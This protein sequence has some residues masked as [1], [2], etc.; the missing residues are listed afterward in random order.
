MRPLFGPHW[1][2]GWLARWLAVAPCR[3]SLSRSLVA[4]RY[5][6]LAF[7]RSGRT[8]VGVSLY[9]LICRCETLTSEKFSANPTAL[10]QPRSTQPWAL[11]DLSHQP[12][13]QQ[14]QAR[15]MRSTNLP[16]HLFDG[17]DPMCLPQPA[18]VHSSSPLRS[19]SV[20]RCFAFGIGVKVR[21]LEGGSWCCGDL[22]Q[23]DQSPSGF[24]G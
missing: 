16:Q 19:T 6:C 7:A 9:Q 21:G 22:P 18:T 1:L 15:P 14:S 20:P 17:P 2:A 11:K 4:K 13:T 8:V 5:S 23:S 10:R 12:A 24:G 3:K